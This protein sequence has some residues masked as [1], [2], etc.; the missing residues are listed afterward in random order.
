MDRAGRRCEREISITEP[1]FSNGAY[2]AYPV[3]KLQRRF[4]AAMKIK[5]T[6]NRDGILL[7]CAETDEGHGDFVSLAIKDRHIEFSFN[8][9]GRSVTIRSDKE[10]RPGEWHVL[11]AT[12]SLSEGRLIVD[13]ETSFGGTPGNHKTLNLLTRLY[14]GGYDSENIKVHDKVGVNSGFNGCISEV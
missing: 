2:I 5:P 1:A 10:V 4:K 6:D 12:R 8:V 7:Y 9:G 13:G 11:T 14:V 3:P